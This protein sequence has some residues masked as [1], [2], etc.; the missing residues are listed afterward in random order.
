MT[1]YND[2]STIERHTTTSDRH[3]G[4]AGIV[5]N[6]GVGEQRGR[7]FS[8][9]VDPPK[10]EPP[11]QDTF[12]VGTA[13]KNH[14]ELAP[15]QA[16]QQNT[17]EG[18]L[19]RVRYESQSRLGARAASDEGPQFSGGGVLPSS[20]AVSAY[21]DEGQWN[22]IFPETIDFKLNL[23]LRDKR[24]SDMA[25]D[26]KPLATEDPKGLRWF[27]KTSYEGKDGDGGLV[28]TSRRG[29]YLNQKSQPDATE[30]SYIR[31]GLC[32]VIGTKHEAFEELEDP[33]QLEEKAISLIC[34][35][36]RDHKYEPF[37]L[38]VTWEYATLRIQKV[39]DEKYTETIHSELISKMVKNY[40][41]KTYIPRKDLVRIMVP[42]VIRQ[43]IDE[44]ES[45]RAKGWTNGHRETFAKNVQRHSSR[46][47]AVCIY[48]GLPMKFLKHLMDHEFRDLDPPGRDFARN[49]QC[50]ERN[51]ADYLF[52]FFQMYYGFFAHKFDPDGIMQIFTE[53][54]VL[55]LYFESNKK[56]N[57]L[58]YG[59]ASIVYE[60][61]IDPVHHSLS[62]V[63][64]PR[65][66]NSLWTDWRV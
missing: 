30:E 3:G 51:C 7:T 61:K 16:S 28:S 60:V 26:R 56:D 37:R 23:L 38:E 33:D 5:P 64:F 13:E 21:S 66:R 31:Y 59:S 34:G 58:G 63:C 48:Q 42:E 22:S 15:L 10:D 50:S 47:Q 55:P 49:H 19:P 25:P 32:R 14:H 4:D 12:G 6:D 27:D 57:Q 29:L 9:T 46:L 53:D 2:L 18:V 44:D 52:K 65:L 8:L 41:G 43:I 36:I 24:A 17:P 39:A 20:S 11:I 35:F 54:D 1:R 40:A 45:L 62:H